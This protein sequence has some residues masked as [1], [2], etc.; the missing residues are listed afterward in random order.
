VTGEWDAE[1]VG[2]RISSKGV[3]NGLDAKG[4]PFN[5]P[6]P[7]RFYGGGAEGYTDYPAHPA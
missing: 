1:H 2:V 5:E 7:A 3:F 6:V 4:L